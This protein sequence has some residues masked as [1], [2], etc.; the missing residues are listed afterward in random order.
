MIAGLLWLAAVA[1][2]AETTFTVATPD[3]WRKACATLEGTG[4]DAVIVRFA[5]EH[6]RTP[7]T[8]RH[9]HVTI[10]GDA[11]EATVELGVGA[12]GAGPRAWLTVDGASDVT[13]EGLT[14]AGGGTAVQ[15]V[16]WDP[17][18]A[19]RTMHDVTIR[20]NHILGPGS[21]VRDAGGILVE[22]PARLERLTLDHNVV[23]GLRVLANGHAVAV[24]ASPA[25][26]P[27]SDILIARNRISDVRTGRSEALTVEGA[28]TDVA[29]VDNVVERYS[30]IGIDVIGQECHEAEG[31]SGT[32]HRIAVVGNTL[33]D[34]E[35]H[36]NGVDAA[37]LYVDGASDTVLAGNVSR[38]GFAGISISTETASPT[39]PLFEH[40][41]VRDNVVEARNAPAL[42]LTH[43]D[44][45]SDKSGHGPVTGRYRDVVIT[46]NVLVHVDANGA[47]RAVARNPHAMAPLTTLDNAIWLEP[48]S[49]PT[50]TTFE[51]ADG[52]ADDKCGE[53][54][55]AIESQR[56]TSRPA[57]RDA[58][59]TWCGGPAPASVSDV[60]AWVTT[61]LDT[62]DR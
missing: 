12:A 25:A 10:R 23:S 56:V 11:D 14:I 28:L 4:D 44:A 60:A 59:P 58:D 19:G 9:D 2:H 30:N 54:R 31:T 21:P 26:S 33:V 29:I 24:R 53:R 15:V 46:G 3:D 45:T 42:V 5:T 52:V 55:A 35:M 43:G 36:G 16:C 51:C 18:C 47:S 62:A 41:R 6:L 20:D 38:A 32:P 13:I 34:H 48:T 1:A 8:I 22:A 40:V 39:A 7:C 50:V 37:A 17:G 27:W 61:C 49:R 57:T